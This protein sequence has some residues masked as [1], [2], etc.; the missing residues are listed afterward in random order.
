M[1]F[2]PFPEVCLAEQAYYTIFVIKKRRGVRDEKNRA[3]D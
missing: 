1:Q 2:L 3:K